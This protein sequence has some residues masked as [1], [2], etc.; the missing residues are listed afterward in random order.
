MSS[1][2]KNQSFAQDMAKQLLPL[3]PNFMKLLYRMV[4][5]RRV[6]VSEKAI[7]LGAVVYILWPL[8]I[9]PDLI[10]FWGQ[11]DDILLTTLVLKRFINSVD[12]AVVLTHWDGSVELLIAIDKILGLTRYILPKG[13]YD[14]I[15]KTNHGDIIDVDFEVK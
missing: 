15:V 3:I 8:D 1:K 12:R 10:P 7:L 6:L 9:L 11:V 2:S 5:D 14:K 4:G 13:L